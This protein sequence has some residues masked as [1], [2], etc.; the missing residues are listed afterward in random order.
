MSQRQPVSGLPWV[1]DLGAYEG[2]AIIVRD[3]ARPACRLAVVWSMRTKGMHCGLPLWP[4]FRPVRLVDSVVFGIVMWASG[5]A[6]VEG[7]EYSIDK[8][9]AC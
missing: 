4:L 1:C 7:P 6:Y 9:E 8:G 3:R 5:D 2:G